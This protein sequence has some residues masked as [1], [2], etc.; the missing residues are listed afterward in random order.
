MS[1]DDLESLKGIFIYSIITGFFLSVLISLGIDVSEEGIAITFLE[2]IAKAFHSPPYIILISSVI[3]T[4]VGILKTLYSVKKIS[5][6]GIHG[7]VVS[8]TGFFG[9][10]AIFLSSL[11]HIGGILYFGVFLWIVGIIIVDHF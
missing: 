9:A 4:V 5:E 8:S 10:L 3:I 11:S 6:Y 2:T 7:Y 1:N